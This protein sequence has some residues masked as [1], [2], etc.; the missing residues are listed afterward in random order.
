MLHER[1]TLL[2][3]F[4]CAA[5]LAA[6][7]FAYG[8][9]VA[10]ANAGDT[11]AAADDEVET[12]LAE[13][14]AGASEDAEDTA[15]EEA[16]EPFSLPVDLSAGVSVISSLGSWTR[17]N[18]AT[19]DSVTSSW[20]FGASRSINDRL[21]V[22]TGMGFSWCLNKNCGIVKPGEARFRDMYLGIGYNSFYVI[23]RADIALSLGVSGSIPTSRISR[24]QNLY[25]A[26][27]SN[28]TMS[29]SFGN[30]SLSYTLGVQKAFHQYKVV[31]QDTDNS[32]DRD[33]L[34]RE[35]G[36]ENVG[37]NQVAEGTGYLT[38][39]SVSNSL[40]AGYRL[41][42]VSLSLGFSLGESFTYRIPDAE[43]VETDSGN[44]INSVSNNRRGRSQ[45]MTG[46]IGMRYS[47]PVWDNRIS[48]SGTMSTT[49]TPKTA[50]NQ[51]IRF[52][53]FDTQSANLSATSMIF[54]MSMF[55]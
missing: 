16:S 46:S 52:P 2:S 44:P 21:S 23:P 18:Y 3:L 10:R 22:S 13:A 40:N 48:L 6:P 24:A 50:D 51:R 17:N 49:Q 19:R 39:W 42:N 55:Y 43:D 28:F 36:A 41:R 30:L 9:D 7:G 29:R 38:E 15:E 31:V 5:V 4:L 27:G 32:F 47:L 1:P 45:L 20:N 54:G 12:L 8:Q 53:F 37:S 25:T 35:G 33:V 34:V 14:E 11:G 26:L